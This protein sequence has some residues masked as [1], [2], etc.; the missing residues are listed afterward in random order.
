MHQSFINVYI[1]VL[2]FSDIMKVAANLLFL[3]LIQNSFAQVNAPIIKINHSEDFEVTGKGGNEAWEATQWVTLYASD[4][5]EQ[6]Q[7]RFKMLYSGSGIYF[8]FQNEDKILSASKTSDFDRLWLEDVVEVF[9]WPDTT[10]TLYFEYEI[11]PLNVELPLLVPNIDNKFLGWLPWQYEGSRKV[12]HF[13]HVEGEKKPNGEIRSWTA[14]FFIPF[15]LLSPLRNVP[16]TRGMKW[17]ANMYRLD[18]DNNEITRWH[19]SKTETNFHQY[20]KFGTVVFN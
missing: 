11:S 10:E 13:T 7:T 14:E 2:H 12:K 8:L 16:P 9:L 4:Q 1:G 15:T 19:W 18:Y 5:Q 6:R 17:K 3:I 20:S